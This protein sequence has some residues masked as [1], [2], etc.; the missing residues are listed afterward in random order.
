MKITTSFLHLE[1]TAALDEKIQESSMKL[2]KFFKA[3]GSVKWSCYVK[4]GQ[5]F[6]EIFYHAPHC[7]Y[8]A[9]AF[10]DNLYHSIDMAM[11]KIEKQAYKKKDK[12]NKI[13]R[14]HVDMIMVDPDMA[15]MDYI[16][17]EDVA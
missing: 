13:H 2:E 3:K 9:K 11:E 10:S 12:Y 5:H 6:A 8:H 7:E 1:H 16:D 15:W 17:D 4:N 14:E